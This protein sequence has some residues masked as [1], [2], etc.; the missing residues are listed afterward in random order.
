[1][2]DDGS[3]PLLPD[4]STDT[5]DLAFRLRRDRVYRALFERPTPPIVIE[6]FRLLRCIG[7]GAMGELYAARDD[8]LERDVA[9]KLVSPGSRGQSGAQLIGEAKKLARLS[10][11]NVVQVF[12]AGEVDG[13]IYIAMELVP[14]VTLAEWLAQ[15]RRWPEIVRAF[16]AAGEGLV[17]A[18]AAN[19]V[20]RDFKP[21]NVLVG[22]D[23]RVRLADFGLAQLLAGAPYGQVEAAGAGERGV[24]EAAG[25]SHL[26]GT[27]SY[28]SPEQWR[29]ER[30]TPA[31]DQFGF[32][33]ALYEALYARHPFGDTTAAVLREAVERGEP[34]SPP[35]GAGVPAAIRRALARGMARSPSDRFGSMSELLAAIG[36]AMH[37]RT[38]RRTTLVV[39]AVLAVAAAG[40]AGLRSR[41][42]DLTSLDLREIRAAAHLARVEA[43]VAQLDHARRHAEA[44]AVFANFAALP[45]HRGTEA[46]ARGWLHDGARLFG[47]G[48]YD[49]AISAFAEA[50]AGAGNG[51]TQRAAL[52][53]LGR[54]W[55]AQYDWRRLGRTLQVLRAR[56][57]RQSSDGAIRELA[58]AHAIANRDFAEAETRARDAATRSTL[59][60]L[61][62]VRHLASQVP[63]RKMLALDM[64]GDGKDS[65]VAIDDRGRTCQLMDTRDGSLR[66]ARAFDGITFAR[67]F[68][69][70][71]RR[72][73][74]DLLIADNSPRYTLMGLV[75]GAI[76]PLHEWRAPGA[77]RAFAAHGDVDGDGEAELYVGYSGYHR[78]LMGLRP[79]TWTR[80]E[81]HPPTNH[82]N[83]NIVGVEVADLDA[84][85]RNELV[86][87]AS[88][89]SAY[90]V[91]ILRATRAGTA[92]PLRLVARRKLGT[93]HWLTLIP[94][95]NGKG[96][97]VAVAVSN[98]YP[99]R[100]VFPAGHLGGEPAGVYLLELR[101]SG[102]GMSLNIAHYIPL[103]GRGITDSVLMRGDLNGD[104]RMDLIFG[105]HSPGGTAVFVQT[106]T[107]FVPLAIEGV[108]PVAVS[109]YDGDRADELV[110]LD[111]RA[112]RYELLGAGEASLGVIRAWPPPS[113]ASPG[114]GDPVL[115]RAWRRAEELAAIGMARRASFVLLR[116]SSM[117]PPPLS[118]RFL[119]RAAQLLEVAKRTT[120]AARVYEQMLAVAPVKDRLGI[121]DKAIRLRERALHYRAALE[122]IGR[123]LALPNVRSRTLHRW[124]RARARLLAMTRRPGVQLDPH[125]ELD[126]HWRIHSPTALRRVGDAWLVNAANP[127]GKRERVIATRRV[128]WAGGAVRL[129]VDVDPGRM[130]WADGLIVRI[131]P[132]GTTSGGVSVGVETGGG[133]G[134]YEHRYLCGATGSGAAPTIVFRDARVRRRRIR[135]AVFPDRNEAVCEVSGMEGAPWRGPSRLKPGDYELA[136]VVRNIANASPAQMFARIYRL[137]LSGVRD[138]GAT[139]QS[140]T[141]ERAYRS[142]S[143]GATVSALRLL[144]RPPP[145][146]GRLA[147]RLARYVAIR[148]TGRR[149]EADAEWRALRREIRGSPCGRVSQLS[150]LVRTHVD[151]LAPV[152][153]RDCTVR[154][155]LRMLWSSWQLAIVLHGDRPD[156]RAMLTNQ[157]NGLLALEP[158]PEEVAFV[159]TLLES[160]AA[161][162]LAADRYAAAR[163]D[164]RR[165]IQVLF[166]ARAR[167]SPI[168]LRALLSTGHRIM[169]AISLAMHDRRA[170]IAHIRASI[171][172]SPSPEIAADRIVA[173]P[174]F[175]SL[176]GGSELT[177][178]IAEA[179]Q[180]RVA[181][182]ARV[183]P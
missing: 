164:G 135:L 177:R 28:M 99:N 98:H 160:R 89:W 10:H 78:E 81:P 181:G 129:V 44:D 53:A 112:N 139:A 83:S 20:H 22:D 144:D 104:G 11:P 33:V 48:D 143:N 116:M 175:R 6:R 84:D 172:I 23:G 148:D 26:A 166:A 161:A 107:G 183:A 133:G 40:F 62:Q 19:L 79:G 150:A 149:A 121:A 132:A 178:L 47:R 64:N 96:V 95:S 70:V 91:R 176:S 131:S 97:W 2:D 182:G 45:E 152:L 153:R 167:V 50:Y 71:A 41:S 109:N 155:Y 13:H 162:Y 140:S 76:A 55:R 93:I 128:H 117:A 36:A 146:A 75:N 42:D 124:R 94:R 87:A 163:T 34:E 52:I 54:I 105:M 9:L 3:A 113:I 7:V 35:A 90:D 29:G 38:R 65:L 103:R 67:G 130:E 85:G 39:A 4:G 126:S 141:L 171:Q 12:D 21:D 158:G 138:I 30:L 27:P 137:E 32:C 14:G 1:M 108:E 82:T 165:S 77:A 60:A 17:A 145:G 8:K 147:Y 170:A 111:S 72:G 100:R 118:S 43:A 37:A 154:A 61:S 142:L 56:W 173:D 114:T 180:G 136:L 174:S 66:P 68:A 151:Y 88:E 25:A 57:P 31:S 125:H 74:P 63:G 51:A 16:V 115:D 102:R 106:A 157:L 134:I 18:H 46:L 179:R 123:A 86:V 80:F 58:L 24:D 5:S 59:R 15:P 168:T 122:L 127:D 169:A 110:V 159:A 101:K 92:Q 156:V 73:L 49:G 119:A 120:E 69:R